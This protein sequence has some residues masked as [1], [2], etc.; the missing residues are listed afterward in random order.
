M[1]LQPLAVAAQEAVYPLGVDEPPLEAGVDITDP[2]ADEPAPLENSVEQPEPEAVIS[3]D[4][5]PPWDLE[6]QANRQWFESGLQRF[7]ATGDVTLRL[8]GGRLQADRLEYSP[9]NRV[10]WARGAVRFQRGN[11]YL[12]ASLLRYNL[13]QGEGEI[14]DVYGVIDLA[15][16]PTDL[17]L[18]A[19]LSGTP[20]G[21]AAEQQQRLQLRANP[22]KP[23]TLVPPASVAPLPAAEP[24]ACPPEIPPLRSRLPGPWAVTAWGGQMTDATFGETFVFS[25]TARP[26]TL[27]GLGVTRRLVDADPFA[28]ELDGNV[29]YHSAT[30]NRRLRYT[31]G[32]P[33]SQKD[34]AVTEAQ[35]FWEGTLGIGIRWWIQPWLSFA[36]I[37]G[38]SL[39]SALSNYEAA[40]WENS[41]QFL[42]YLAAEIAIQFNHQWSAV[43]RIHHRSGAY[44]TYSG[45]EEAVTATSSA[46]VR[47]GTTAQPPLQGETDPPPLGCPGAEPVDRDRFLLLEQQLESVVFD[48]H[49]L[50]KRLMC[51]RSGGR[52]TSPWRS[53][54]SSGAM[55]LPHWIN[56]FDVQPR[57]G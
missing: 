24:M 37:E 14:Q 12:Q 44:G 54:R 30:L 20:Q 53:R 36:A 35:N 10:I 25:G 51:S 6:L 52:A 42:N 47:F 22:P 55:P 50:S 15:T 46:F 34:R 39:N 18:D 26:E 19:P 23:G 17:N 43:G 8:A 28:I 16:S 27:F 9:A 29:L 32:I 5:L 57:S 4:L 1:L 49:Q 40:S 48:G 45:A 13:L 3:E 7:V 38:V 11:Q 21:N 31:G 2:F 33:D 56:G 41:A